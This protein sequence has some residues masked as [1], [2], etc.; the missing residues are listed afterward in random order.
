MTVFR[1]DKTF[2]GLL[3]ALFDAYFRRTFPEKLLGE[4]DIEPMFAEGTHTVATDREKAGRVW[5]RIEETLPKT[6]RNMV[7]YVWLSEQEGSD[8]LLLRYLRK[9]IDH[10]GN[11]SFNFTDPDVLEMKQ[12]AQKVE[13]EAEHLRQFVRFQK[14]ADGS[15]FAP[16]SPLY[17]CLPVALGYFTDR[18][19]DQS[20]L[21]Y[22]VKRRYGFYYDTESVREVTITQDE[23]LL[24]GKLTDEMM[25]EDER[26]FQMLW[27]NYLKTLTIRERLNPKL[28]R[29]HMPRRFWKFLTEKQ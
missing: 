3:T 6:A 2:E 25:A 21:I 18:F 23:H 9:I 26:L 4:G 5:R 13:R 24:S 11:Y 1:Y 28:Q 20:W 29:Q 14:G 27:K 15:Y 12:L 7:M 22:D 19:A 17:N 16:V 8:E 10:G